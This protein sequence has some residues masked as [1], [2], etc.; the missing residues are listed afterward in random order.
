VV[1]GVTDIKVVNQW[2]V[3]QVDLVVL[4]LMVVLV[5]MEM[6]LLQVLP[7]VIM[8]VQVIIVHN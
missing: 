7:K 3:I 1:V 5:E 4:D 6:T 2:L 8:V